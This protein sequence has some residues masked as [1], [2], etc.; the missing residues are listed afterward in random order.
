MIQNNKVYSNQGEYTTKATADKNA[1]SW[2]KDG[3]AVIVKKTKDGKYGI[4]VRPTERALK[5]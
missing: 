5:K 2:R 3:F 4:Y 1:R